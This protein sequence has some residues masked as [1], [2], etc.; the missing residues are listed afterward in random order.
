MRFDRVRANAWISSRAGV[1][2]A[3]TDALSLAPEQQ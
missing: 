3:A 2:G 1:R